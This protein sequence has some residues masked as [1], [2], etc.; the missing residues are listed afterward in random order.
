MRIVDAAHLDAGWQRQAAHQT[1]L[2]ASATT[3]ATA[4]TQQPL[5]RLAIFRDE[6][7]VVELLRIAVQAGR[8]DAEARVRQ[9]G[10]CA[11]RA[12]L[13]I[14]PHRQRAFGVGIDDDGQRAAIQRAQVESFATQWQAG[15]FTAIGTDQSQRALVQGQPAAAGQRGQFFGVVQRGRHRWCSAPCR[16]GQGAG[17]QDGLQDRRNGLVHQ[18]MLAFRPIL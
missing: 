8:F 3:P 16:R 2:V 14:D 18:K 17:Q 11:Q 1:V 9:H 5:L 10:Q 13:D 4:A 15:A 12:G 7:H 6:E